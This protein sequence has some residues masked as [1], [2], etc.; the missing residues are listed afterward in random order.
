D[1]IKAHEPKAVRNG[2]ELSSQVSAGVPEQIVGDP[3]RIRQILSNLVSNAV[4]FTEHGSVS[5]RMD[6]EPSNAEGFTLRFTVA[7]T[8]TGIPA[9]KLLAIFEKFTQADG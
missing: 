8:G 3:L 6:G 7:D 1:C 5:V 2:I 9:D 4:K